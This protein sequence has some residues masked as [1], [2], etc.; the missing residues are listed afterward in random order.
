MKCSNWML[1]AHGAIGAMVAYIL[2]FHFGELPV[3]AKITLFA[4]L[5][6]ILFNGY[7]FYKISQIWDKEEEEELRRRMFERLMK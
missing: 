6:L 1:F 2:A 4:S 7:Q 5:P 3:I